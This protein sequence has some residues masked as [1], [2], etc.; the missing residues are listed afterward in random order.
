MVR[1]DN[2]CVFYIYLLN[3][4]IRLPYFQNPVRSH[5]WS[6]IYFKKSEQSLFQNQSLYYYSVSKSRPSKESR[7][8]KKER[9]SSSN[10]SN[11]A[12]STKNRDPRIRNGPSSS[13]SSSSR[14]LFKNL[15]YAS[16]TST[17]TLIN[18][19]LALSLF[20]IS[21]TFFS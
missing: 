1:F 13:S 14:S 17:K 6:Q 21:T 19:N 9:A 11:N 12:T 18:P 8:S 20:A 15:I 7:K 5:L 4:L 16:V 3:F 10:V 2:L